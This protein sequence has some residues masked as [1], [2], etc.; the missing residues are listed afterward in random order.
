M[1]ASRATAEPMP[2]ATRRSA[3]WRA[4]AALGAV[5]QLCGAG[6][7]RFHVP[8]P[9]VLHA[10]DQ[11]EDF[12][13]DLGAADRNPWLVH[14]P[15]LQNFLDLIAI[16]ELP[17]LFHQLGQG[18]RLRGRGLDGHLRAGGVQSGA[19]AV[20]GQP[21]AGDRGVPDL[22]GPGF[23]AVHPAVPDLWA[24]SA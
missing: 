22:P 14:H 13:G 1:S 4:S 3:G 23:A 16:A 10:G 5:G 11:P 6:R 2:L 18:H 15:T 8:G 21:D 19:D 7:V 17:A 9:A 12:G 24:S 20:L